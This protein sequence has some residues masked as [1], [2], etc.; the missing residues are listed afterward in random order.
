LILKAATGRQRSVSILEQRSEEIL[1]PY[2]PAPTTQG[3]GDAQ[4]LSEM[5]SLHQLEQGPAPRYHF[6]A[7]D[8]NEAAHYRLSEP[9][10]RGL[11]SVLSPYAGNLLRHVYATG[12]ATWELARR[13]NEKA[14]LERQPRTRYA[15]VGGSGNCGESALIVFTVLCHQVD[16]STVESIEL[17]DSDKDSNI[18]NHAFVVA[19]LQGGQRIVHDH[20]T[21]PQA[22]RWEHYRFSDRSDCEVIL[23]WRPGEKLPDSLDAYVEQSVEDALAGYDL[24]SHDAA[25]LA[26][27]ERLLQLMEAHQDDKPSIESGLR[28]ETDCQLTP[29][30]KAQ[31]GLGPDEV[32]V[33]ESP[34]GML[35]S[36]DFVPR[37]HLDEIERLQLEPD[38]QRLIERCKAAIEWKALLFEACNDDEQEEVR[39]LLQDQVRPTD[40]PMFCAKVAGQVRAGFNDEDNGLSPLSE[41]TKQ[42]LRDAGATWIES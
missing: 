28:T 9:L 32:I 13:Q 42:A 23:S 4:I 20:W 24:R 10:R 29:E 18:R 25:D 1:G 41:S 37:A 6:V 8:Q 19:T 36:N 11:R 22:C 5:G 15:M 16:P 21:G 14:H 33:Y 27:H 40:F 39:R 3:R 12:G 30:Q 2:G 7:V 38:R 26:P 31:R 17:M 34:D 35:F